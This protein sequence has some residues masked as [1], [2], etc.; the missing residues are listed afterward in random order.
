M[1]MNLL[2]LLQ[3][4]QVFLSDVLWAIRWRWELAKR[5]RLEHNLVKDNLWEYWEVVRSENSML[6]VWDR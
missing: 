3:K 2:S 1:W 6:G 5:K 4:L